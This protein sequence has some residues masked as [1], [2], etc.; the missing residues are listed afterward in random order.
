[1]RHPMR[2]AVPVVLLATTL[3]TTAC[4]AGGQDTAGATEGFPLTVENCGREVTF[5]QRPERLYVIGGEAGTL[6][7]AAGG[8]DRISTFSPLVGEPLGDAAGPLGEREQAPIKTSTDISREAII[9]A[10]PDLVVTFGLNDFSPEDLESSGIPTLVI[11]GYCGGFG[12]GQSDVEE[13]IQGI[14]DDVETLGRILGTEDHAERSVTDLR[15]RVA[16]VREEAEQTPPPSGSTAA[17]FFPG[18]DGALG[19]YGKRSMVHEQMSHLGLS[20]V[21]TDTDERYF[22]VS[23]ESLIEAAPQRLIALYEPGD[24]DEEAVRTS[25]T[26]RPELGEIPA[27]STG[28]V[29]V[30]EFFYSGHGTLAVDGL[31]QLSAQIR[32]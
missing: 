27:I 19:A 18:P 24:T 10:S 20:N 30:L 22:D 29:L 11:S 7:H 3:A 5:E 12:A 4:G 23:T 9:G 25:L 6:V 21:F 31:E 8:T 16:E 2:A 13:P 28:E 1:M 17:V 14:Y 15:E 32:G 26:G